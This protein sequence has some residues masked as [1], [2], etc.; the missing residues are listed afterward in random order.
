MKHKVCMSFDE[1]MGFNRKLVHIY[2]KVWTCV[3]MGNNCSILLTE[4]S[5]QLTSSINITVGSDNSCNYIVIISNFESKYIHVV[6]ISLS[7]MDIYKWIAVLER[8]VS[9]DKHE[10]RVL[11]RREA[12]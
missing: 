10:S 1:V 9:K 8:S 6:T 3:Q 2:Q 4:S 11:F 5:H 7:G 12:C